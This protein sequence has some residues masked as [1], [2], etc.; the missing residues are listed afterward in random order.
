MKHLLPCALLLFTPAAFAGTAKFILHGGDTERTNA[1]VTFDAP[2]D[3]RGDLLLQ[4]SD[5]SAA[6][7]QVDAAGHATF[8]V[9]RIGKGVTLSY[10]LAPALPSFKTTG[11]FAKK[12]GA[13]LE[14]R[15]AAA[16]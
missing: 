12:E 1:I 3:V 14:L 13:V 11:V 9:D 15:A 2:S 8:V 4:G 5:G 10:S 6:P 7:L 16:D